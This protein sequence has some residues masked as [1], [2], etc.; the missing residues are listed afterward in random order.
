VRDIVPR[1]HT[2]RGRRVERRFGWDCHGL[3]AEQEAEKVLGVNGGKE[4]AALGM[5][6]STTRAA[7]RC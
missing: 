3:P 2:M 6:S 1:Y 5:A 7:R 4:I